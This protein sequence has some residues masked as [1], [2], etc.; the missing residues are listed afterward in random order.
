MGVSM[1]VEEKV[2]QIVCEQLGV[3]SEEEVKPEEIDIIV[4]LER[5]IPES[6]ILLQNAKIITMN[7]DQI[8]ENGDILIKN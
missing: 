6:T 4:K 8:I 3:S 5:D 7:G 1:N 2:Q